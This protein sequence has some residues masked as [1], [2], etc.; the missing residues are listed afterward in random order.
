MKWVI[1]YKTNFSNVLEYNNW[2][3]ILITLD[4]VYDIWISLVNVNKA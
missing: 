2:M 1:I 4:A 3:T